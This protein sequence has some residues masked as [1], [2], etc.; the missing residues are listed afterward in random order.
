MR[1][2]EEQQSISTVKKKLPSEADGSGRREGKKKEEIEDTYHCQ[3]LIEAL[4]LDS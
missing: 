4:C 1:N 2:C 3:I